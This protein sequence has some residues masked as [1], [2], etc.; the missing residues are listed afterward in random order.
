[1]N[2]ALL[3]SNPS[4]L[5]VAGDHSPERPHVGGEGFEGLSYQQL[6]ERVD[7]CNAEFVAT[8]DRE[9]QTMTLQS[10]IRR[11][12]DNISSRIVRVH[13]HRVGPDVF[14]GR[15]EAY[16]AGDYIR[17]RD[18]HKTRLESDANAGL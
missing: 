1:M 6:F 13:I 4:Q 3:R 16:I 11:L 10:L 9:G 14:F 5:T 18:W 12:Q 8:P 17:D 2:D 15:R 7:R